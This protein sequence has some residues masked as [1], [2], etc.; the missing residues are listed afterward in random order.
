MDLNLDTWGVVFLAGLLTS[1]PTNSN[2][3]R[4]QPG[5]R[6]LVRMDEPWLDN[7]RVASTVLRIVFAL[8]LNRMFSANRW[9][10]RIPRSSPI[11]AHR[12]IV[13]VFSVFRYLRASRHESQDCFSAMWADCLYICR[14][15]STWFRSYSRLVIHP[16]MRNKGLLL[17]YS[18]W[19]ISQHE[20]V[21]MRTVSSIAIILV[22]RMI[23]W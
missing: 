20:R 9:D 12:I 21:G 3:N 22:S 15:C 18:C 23:D 4:K 14:G 16:R 6:D 7:H 13:S 17:L 10:I 19:G 5:A 8:L 2:N 1:Q 11:P